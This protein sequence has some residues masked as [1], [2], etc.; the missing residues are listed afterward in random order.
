[1]RTLLVGLAA[2]LCIG[3]IGSAQ[4]ERRMFI[5]ANGGD[6][7]GIDRC[8]ATGDKCGAAAANAYCKSNEFASAASYRKVDRD[9]I[10]GAIPTGGS[11]GC[12]GNTCDVVA[13]VC[14]R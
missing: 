11:G 6:G 7:Y 12:R 14:T 10:T 1:M 5:I 13:I 4:A 9:D 2:I 8:L 3:L